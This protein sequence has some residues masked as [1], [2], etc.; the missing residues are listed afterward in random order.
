MQLYW[1]TTKPSYAPLE[2]IPDNRVY[3]S[4][5]RA[6]AFV[7]AFVRFAHGK[8]DSDDPRAPGIEIGRQEPFRRIRL[9]SAFGKMVVLATNGH[10]PYPYGAETTGYEVADLGKTLDAARANGATVLTS[11]PSSAMVRF[12]G[13][14]VCE[15]HATAS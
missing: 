9:S 10:L 14:Y 5:D 12:P 1:H 11:R 3:V 2:T 7:S 6:D 8:I 13:G 15:I 4:T